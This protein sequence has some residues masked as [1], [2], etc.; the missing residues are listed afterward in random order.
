MR[1]D[2]ERH[3]DVLLTEFMECQLAQ[4]RDQPGQD[5][6]SYQSAAVDFICLTNGIAMKVLKEGK[7]EDAL[8]ILSSGLRQL[9]NVRD[10]SVKATTFNNLGCYYRSQGEYK[11]VLR[12]GSALSSVALCYIKLAIFFIINVVGGEE[13]G[14][15]WVSVT[16]VFGVRFSRGQAALQQRRTRRRVVVNYLPKCWLLLS[17]RC[18]QAFS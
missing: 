12:C 11:K 2:K 10:L 8:R 3:P 7:P 1:A 17:L 6:E 15:G 13:H 5:G 18:V 9:A 14:D 16:C 4:L